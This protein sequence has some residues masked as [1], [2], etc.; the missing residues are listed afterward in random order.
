MSAVQNS[1]AY[2]RQTGPS[3]GVSEDDTWRRR[4]DQV[5]WAMAGMPMVAQ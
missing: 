4:E 2:G 3:H 1:M 5:V